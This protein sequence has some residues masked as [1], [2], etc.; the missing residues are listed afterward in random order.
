MTAGFFDDIP[1]AQSPPSSAGFFDD[2]PVAAPLPP[3]RPSALAYNSDALAPGGNV[4]VD[5]GP[6]LG[7]LGSIDA[8]PAQR[9]EA[10][11]PPVP[12]A[13]EGM[14]DATPRTGGT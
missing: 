11:G 12:G 5:P 8:R 1:I 9:P 3:A 2:I 7:Q 10:Q 6:Q 4:N 14:D 13:G